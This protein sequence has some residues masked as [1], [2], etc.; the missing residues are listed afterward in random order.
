M[1]PVAGGHRA[2]LEKPNDLGEPGEK[3]GRLR[4]RLARREESNGR[5]QPLV[6]HGGPHAKE[7]TRAGIVDARL[8]A[9][10]LRR[11]EP[12]ANI[13]Y[14]ANLID[15]DAAWL[16]LTYTASGNPMDYRVRLV[17]TQ[18]TY[19]GRRWWFLCP[20][21]RKDGG[22]PRRAAKLY[23]PPA[24]GISEAVKPTGSPTGHARR[25]GS[26]TD[27]FVCSRRIWGRT[28]RPSGFHLPSSG[29]RW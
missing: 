11:L 23:L 29:L 14:E 1:F 10:V 21:A 13:G 17:T 28:R 5:G 4:I 9:M 25:A 24:G 6:V 22:P 16:R 3:N 8:L 27:C 15:P 26:S 19:G 20:L 7:G 12:H 18:P 2:A